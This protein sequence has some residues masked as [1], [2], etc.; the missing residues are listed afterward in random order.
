MPL[1]TS[2]AQILNDFSYRR[3]C[4]EGR[5]YDAYCNNYNTK[6]C[7]QIE[8]II[9]A[10]RVYKN[11]TGDDAF[12]F[13]VSCL[14]SVTDLPE[15]ELLVPWGYSDNKHKEVSMPAV[16]KKKLRQRVTVTG[17]DEGIQLPWEINLLQALWI[18][19]Q[20]TTSWDLRQVEKIE[21]LKTTVLILSQ[22]DG[23]D[24]LEKTSE[25]CSREAYRRRV[26]KDRRQE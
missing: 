1:K 11:S 8:T 5:C 17:R 26:C 14:P 20:S 21:A 23:N 3:I 2:A 22:S 6:Y 24:G 25:E 4:S 19:I 9:E 13:C 7:L 18:K 12:V 10:I 16:K 15:N